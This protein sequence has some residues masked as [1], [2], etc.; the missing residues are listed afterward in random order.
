[1]AMWRLG[2]RAISGD[3]GDTLLKCLKFRSLGW[4]LG[5]KKANG[6]RAGKPAHSRSG[7]RR[8]WETGLQNYA[9]EKLGESWIDLVARADVAEWA[10][11]FAH[12]LMP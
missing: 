5:E 10:H 8:R 1:M 6:A 4:W 11:N 12:N 9:T 2:V 3:M 7:P